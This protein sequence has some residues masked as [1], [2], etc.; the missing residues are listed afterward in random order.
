MLI[1]FGYQVFGGP[2]VFAGSHQHGILDRIKDDLRVDALFLAQDLDR[3]INRSQ[4][5]MN[6]LSF[7]PGLPLEFEIR[8]FHLV[9]G[10]LHASAGG[11]FEGNDSFRETFQRADPMAL[12]LDGLAQ[13]YFDLLPNKSLE[14]L[15]P[16]Q[17]SFDSRRTDFERVARARNDILY[18]Q[19]GADVVGNKFTIGMS[20]AR[21]FVDKNA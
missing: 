10:E 19:N 4:A 6:P 1:E 5:H 13:H 18:V 20:D 8:L 9:E 21:G 2:E 14:F 15:G 12:I 11:R 7:F 16:G 3:L 17:L